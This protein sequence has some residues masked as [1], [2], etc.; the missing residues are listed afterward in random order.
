MFS[1]RLLVRNYG[2]ENGCLLFKSGNWLVS[3]TFPKLKEREDTVCCLPAAPIWVSF[4]LL[5][6]EEGCEA[7]FV[8]WTW[9]NPSRA[10][11]KAARPTKQRRGPPQA[12]N[13]LT[14]K[15]YQEGNNRVTSP[16]QPPP[17][18]P[19]GHSLV[20]LPNNDGYFSGCSPLTAPICPMRGSV[21]EETSDGRIH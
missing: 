5:S 19:P 4:G 7:V 6:I 9:Q 8:C 11:L 20:S 3:Q 21:R 17:P 1:R 2:V 13:H 12:N 14:R 15:K 16:P 10:E 18:P